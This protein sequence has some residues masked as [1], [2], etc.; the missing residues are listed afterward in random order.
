MTPFMDTPLASNTQYHSSYC[1]ARA[2]KHHRVA[3]GCHQ[4]NIWRAEL[5]KQNPAKAKS[6][7]NKRVAANTTT[8]SHE[9]PRDLSAEIMHRHVRHEFFSFKYVNSCFFSKI[10]GRIKSSPIKLIARIVCYYKSITDSSAASAT[11]SIF[12]LRKLAFDLE[13]TQRRAFNAIA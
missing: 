10:I 11:M 4:P 1:E 5:S 6:K 7:G 2:G 13:A 12:P 9:F 3:N 8:L